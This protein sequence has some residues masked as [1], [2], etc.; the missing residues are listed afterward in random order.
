M[1]DNLQRQKLAWQRLHGEPMPAAQARHTLMQMMELQTLYFEEESDSPVADPAFWARLAAAAGLSVSE[2]SLASRLGPL[3][4]DV[5][6]LENDDAK[7]IT[8]EFNEHGYTVVSTADAGVAEDLC[9]AVARGIDAV[10]A[11]GL[12]PVFVLVFDETWL[13]LSLQ[14]RFLERSRVLGDSGVEIRPDINCW[15]L[16][17]PLPADEAQE[18]AVER[19][20][21]DNFPERH[22]D[23]RYDQCHDPETDAVT[24]LSV[25][26]AVNPS[27]ATA[28]NGAM[29]CVPI[30]RDPLF[31]CA[32]HPDHM[33][34]GETVRGEPDVLEAPAG[35]ACM[36]VPSLVHFGGNMRPDT[37]EEPRMSVAATFRAVPRCGFNGDGVV[38]DPDA[39]EGA[40]PPPVSKADLL[41]LPLNRRLAHAAKAVLAYSHWYPG[42]P[43]IDLC[44]LSSV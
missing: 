43:G 16:R 36:W 34:T 19:R 18:P 15:R 29:R 28:G 41:R 4:E 39:D 3:E 10:T 37:V 44:A 12:P 20:P 9:A 33:S 35:H 6:P 31:Y 32:D 2:E 21:G 14:L 24:A 1:K 11:A 38:G 17:R 13:L 40:G 42:L 5:T 26:V 30:D 25:W 23:L 22:R 7:H 8:E 27:G